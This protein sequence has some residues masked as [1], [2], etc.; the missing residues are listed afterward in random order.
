MKGFFPF[1]RVAGVKNKANSLFYNI[2]I[3]LF[4]YVWLGVATRV[5][6]KNGLPGL[7]TLTIKVRASYN[8]FKGGQIG[9]LV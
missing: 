9:G 6:S 8:A 4:F 7:F 2:L 1:L 3:A 5:I